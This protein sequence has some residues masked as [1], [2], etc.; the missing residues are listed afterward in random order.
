VKVK[1]RANFGRNKKVAVTETHANLQRTD[2]TE[3][4]KEKVD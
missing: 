3:R 1:R 2:E 4:P